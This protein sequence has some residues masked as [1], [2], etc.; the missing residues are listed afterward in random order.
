MGPFNEQVRFR[1][2]EMPCCKHSLC[3]LNPRLP[4]YCPECG[5]LVL[6]QM[7]AAEP[8]IDGPAIMR[9]VPTKG[10]NSDVR[11]DS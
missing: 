9:V 11:T 7:R 5:K 2:F 3:W 4:N 8:V 1:L 10:V 6:L